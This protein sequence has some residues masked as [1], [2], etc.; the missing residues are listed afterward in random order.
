MSRSST[1]A[2]FRR[3]AAVGAVAAL[4]LASVVAVAPAG[5]AQETEAAFNNG[6]GK[7][8]AVLNRVVPGVGSLELGMATGVAV[9]EFTNR[10]AQS[11]AQAMDMGL[12]GTSLTAEGCSGDS[13]I[14][15]EDLPQPLRVDNRQGDTTAERDE[16]P[17][18]GEA[19]G[20]GRL[21]VEATTVPSSRAVATGG[22]SQLG[23]V[24]LDGGQAEA[25]TEIIPG[26]A[27]I[28]RAVVESAMEIAGVV[29]FHGMRWEALHRTGEGAT[30]TGS[31][32]LGGADVGGVPLPVDQL[33]VVEDAVNTALA[34]TGIQIEMPTVQRVEEPVDFVR[35]TPLRIIMQDSEAGSTLLGPVLGGTREQR[36]QLFQ[37][38]TESICE[39][40]GALLVADIALSVVAGTG[41]LAVEVGGV[42]A[43][44][45]DMV[46]G[47]PFGTI[48]TL[49]GVDVDVDV[50]EGTPASPPAPGAPGA[51]PGAGPGTVEGT[52]MPGTHQAAV[53]TEEVCE[54]IHP[55]RWPPCSTGAA[56]PVGL[57]GLAATALMAGLDWRRQRRVLAGGDGADPTPVAVA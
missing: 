37:Q 41:F 29:R 17:V 44:S 52:A 32:E 38:L 46:V 24:T 11:Q 1:V 14:R 28:A 3:T 22:K 8:V 10:L 19:F 57:A 55:F 20:G 26:T 21:R 45:I 56:L 7:A 47:N 48:E 42:E 18:A 39:A 30:A 9:A 54:S 40:G 12:V 34:V 53:A 35:V 5:Q 16:L 4:A 51:G 27:R 31:F 50:T 25:V 43:T 33:G 36:E 6:H 23:L 49:P 15:P 2:A 13:T